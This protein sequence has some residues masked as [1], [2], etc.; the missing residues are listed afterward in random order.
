[1]GYNRH[2]PGSEVIGVSMVVLY[3]VIQNAARFRTASILL[4]TVG[5]PGGYAI[6]G[7]PLVIS[8]GKAVPIF[9][10]AERKTVLPVSSAAECDTTAE[11]TMQDLVVGTK[12]CSDGIRFTWNIKAKHGSYDQSQSIAMQDR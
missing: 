12:P 9:G 5:L 6:D 7:R 3:F 1:M 2:D 10:S 4:P 11:K 8:S